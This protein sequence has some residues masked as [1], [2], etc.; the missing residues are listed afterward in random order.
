M[1]LCQLLKFC[2]GGEAE[3]RVSGGKAEK[4]P[5]EHGEPEATTELVAA[6]FSQ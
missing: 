2:E 5:V 1:L 4:C 6:D 3:N